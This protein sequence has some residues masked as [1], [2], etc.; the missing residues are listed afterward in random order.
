MMGSD[1]FWVQPTPQDLGKAFSCF[2]FNRVA[3]LSLPKVSADN[4]P[5]YGK[6]TAEL[7]KEAGKKFV[8][9]LSAAFMPA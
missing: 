7:K 6:A 4:N 9:V 3:P 2:G 1:A 5:A 8:A